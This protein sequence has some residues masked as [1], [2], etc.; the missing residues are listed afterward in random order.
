MSVPAFDYILTTYIFQLLVMMLGELDYGDMMYPEDE[1]I[2][3]SIKGNSWNGTLNGDVHQQLFPFSAHALLT[4][5]IIFVSI[6]LMN[7]LFG[8]AVNDVEV[9]IYIFLFFIIKLINLDITI[10]FQQSVYIVC[11]SFVVQQIYRTADR[12]LLMSQI[13]MVQQKEEMIKSNA[14]LWLRRLFREKLIPLLHGKPYQDKH[15]VIEL[16]H[17]ASNQ[18]EKDIYQQCLR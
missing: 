11:I 16:K 2:T 18:L 1:S 8:L 15:Y 17:D 12:Q 9:N 3:G 7:F 4:T 13:E 14:P 6:I 5:F 10:G